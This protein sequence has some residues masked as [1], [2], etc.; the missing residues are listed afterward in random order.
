MKRERQRKGERIKQSERE[1]EMGGWEQKH[2][3]P[4]CHKQAL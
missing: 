1:K 2:M 3:V 4:R